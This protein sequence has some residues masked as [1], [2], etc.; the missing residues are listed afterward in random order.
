MEFKPDDIVREIGT[1]YVGIVQFQF[2][3]T[4]SYWVYVPGIGNKEL[5][6]PDMK[7]VKR[8][9]NLDTDEKNL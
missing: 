1:S 3:L 5:S 9:S 6:G 4:D 2:K 7:L 8:N